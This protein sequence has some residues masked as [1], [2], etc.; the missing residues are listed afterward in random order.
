MHDFRI[1]GLLTWCA[2]PGLDLSAGL[3][4]NFRP[5]WN[6]NMHGILTRGCFNFSPPSEKRPLRLNR[7]EVLGL[8]NTL[9]LPLSH[10]GGGNAWFWTAS[11][12]A[13]ILATSMTLFSSLS[14]S[15]LLLPTG[16]S[17]L[18]E[19]C[20]CTVNSVASPF[21]LYD[22]VTD[23]AHHLSRSSSASLSMPIRSHVLT[24][25]IQKCQQMWVLRS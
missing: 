9:P 20:I 7:A 22:I 10:Q 25:L 15:D 2:T 24:P 14:L 17:Y 1:F 11:L 5:P 18:Q 4:T 21:I 6:C 3:Q 16:T 12:T 8:T 19:F 23:T 13:L